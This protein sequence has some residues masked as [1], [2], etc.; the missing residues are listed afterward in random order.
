MTEVTRN[1]FILY[2]MMWQE[3]REATVLSVSYLTEKLHLIVEKRG[4]RVGYDSIY[5]LRFNLNSNSILFRIS[6]VHEFVYTR[7]KVERLWFLLDFCLRCK[8]K[9]GCEKWFLS[10]PASHL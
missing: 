7:A 6:K 1:H 5:S 3:K 8:Y 10:I 9:Q 4:K 2:F